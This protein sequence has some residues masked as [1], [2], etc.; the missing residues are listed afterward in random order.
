MAD[1][2][3]AFKKTETTIP[4]MQLK[5]LNRITVDDSIHD[6]WDGKKHI[7]EHAWTTTGPR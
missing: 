7:C 5:H 1:S 2:P 6:F 4:H 3:A